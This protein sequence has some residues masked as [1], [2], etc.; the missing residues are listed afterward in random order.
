MPIAIRDPENKLPALRKGFDEVRA[1]IGKQPMTDERWENR[2][3]IA[4]ALSLSDDDAIEALTKAL[5]YQDVLRA[6]LNQK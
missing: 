4:W 6:K 1:K 3:R 5:A 2:L